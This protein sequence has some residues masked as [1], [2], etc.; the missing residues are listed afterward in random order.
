VD[1]SKKKIEFGSLGGCMNGW[2]N[3]G[4]MLTNY[5]LW[6]PLKCPCCFKGLKINL[7]GLGSIL[8]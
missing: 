7:N 6:L 1:Y 4:V 8:T 2:T 5:A 3:L